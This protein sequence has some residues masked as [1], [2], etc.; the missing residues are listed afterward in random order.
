VR[1]SLTPS[2]NVGMCKRFSYLY[3][4]KIILVYGDNLDF[5]KRNV[6]KIN[7]YITIFLIIFSIKNQHVFIILFLFIFS[8][9]VSF[10]WWTEKLQLMISLSIWIFNL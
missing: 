10:V 2:I 6:Y 4:V 3:K 9:T 8:I 5:N 1:K 7:L